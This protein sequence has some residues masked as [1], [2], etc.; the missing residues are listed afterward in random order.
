MRVMLLALVIV[1]QTGCQGTNLE[2]MNRSPE[3]LRETPTK[4][5]VSAYAV[6]REFFGENEKLRTE[7]K[8][9]QVL[10]DDEWIRADSA[11]VA[12]GDPEE[13]VWIAWGKPDDI[14]TFSSA[15]GDSRLLIYGN[16]AENRVYILN[17]RVSALGQ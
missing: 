6:H 9:R 10:R 14:H 3:A 13:L 12:I 5:L 1:A 17:G 16:R 8:S 7:L 4:E 15:G 2:V 11:K